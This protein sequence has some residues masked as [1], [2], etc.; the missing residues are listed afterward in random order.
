MKDGSKFSVVFEEEVLS[1][2]VATRCFTCVCVF[3]STCVL[4]REKRDDEEARRSD[5]S[6]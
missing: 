4:F 2:S 3:C 1:T 5:H 6:S